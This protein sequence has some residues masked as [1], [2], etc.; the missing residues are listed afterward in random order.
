M[1]NL[2]TFE[3]FDP[4]S[5][6]FL[7]D[8]VPMIKMA[9]KE[10]PVFYYPDL[11]LWVVT[12]YDDICRAARDYKT[13]SSRALGM[14]PP[15]EHLK[16]KVPDNFVEEHFV[17]IDPPEHTASRKAVT[18]FFSKAEIQ[19]QEEPIRETANALIDEFIDNGQCDIMQEFCYPLSL[20]VIIRFLGIPPERPADYRQW[21]EDLFSIFTPKSKDAVS[22]PM[23]EEERCERWSR[24]VQAADFFEALVDERESNPRDDL[25]SALLQAKDSEGNPAINRT[26][27]IRHISELVAAGNDTTANL[28]GH[29]L[30]F[31]DK[32]RT[33]LEAVKHDPNLMGNAVEEVLRRRGSSPGLFRITTADVEIGDTKIPKDSLVWLLFIGGGSDETHFTDSERFDIHRKNADKHIS[34]GYGRHLCLGNQLA[35]LECRV[36]M[37]TLFHRIPDIRVVPNQELEYLPVMTVVTLKNLQVEWDRKHS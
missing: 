31:L 25:V 9:Q 34:F 26:R 21:T 8:P 16:A 4:F 3:G 5:P 24:L 14:V 11:R 20:Q 32:D 36:A 7:K 12:R 2:P 17:S 35:R 10:C 1:T 15:P 27:I 6:E 28:M 22:K 33:Q 29:L 37:Q 18:G 19:R 30:M 13:F 23:S